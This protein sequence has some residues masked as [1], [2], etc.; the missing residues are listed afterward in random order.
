MAEVV[1]IE[2]DGRALQV[3]PGSRLLDIA[4]AHG[5]TIPRFC[6]HKKLSLAASCRMCLVEVEKA[7]K[8]M[9]ACSTQ[10]ME[11][12]VVHTR[13][14]RAIASQR[15][16]MEF[17]L[18]NHPLDCPICD[19]GGE[20]QLQEMAMGYGNDSSNYGETKRE[21]V[22]PDLGP[23]IAT[24]MNRCIHCT[25]CVRFGAEIAGMMELGAPGRGETMHISTF[26]AKTVDSEISAN[27]I[28]LC[29]VGALTSKPFRYKARPWELQGVE[30]VSLHD[31]MT[32]PI[33]VDSRRG[34]VM[35][36]VPA[37]AGDAWIADRD[38]FAY[39]GL[40]SGDRLTRPMIKRDGLWKEVEWDRALTFAAEGLQK[41][42]KSGGG[43]GVAALAGTTST[44][45]EYYLLQKLMRGL[46]SNHLD[47]RLR[48]IDF[49]D[50]ERA[51]IYPGLGQPLAAIA[52]HDSYLLIGTDLR[53]EQPLL[54]QKVREANRKGAKVLVVNPAPFP[55][56]MSLTEEIITTPSAL[57]TE[58]AAIAAAVEVSTGSAALQ[59]IITA[60]EITPHHQRI[61]AALRESSSGQILLGGIALAHPQLS[62]LRALAEQIAA[63]CNAQLGYAGAGGNSAGAALAGFL[64]HYGVGGVALAEKGKSWREMSASEI[65]GVVLLNLEPELDGVD[66]AALLAMLRQTSFNVALTAFVSDEM[67][68]YADVLLPLATA[69]ETSGTA[70]NGAGETVTL[71][72]ALPLPGESRPGWKVLRVLGNLLNL[73]G[74]EQMSSAEVTTEVEAFTTHLDPAVQ[75]GASQNGEIPESFPEFPQGDGLQRVVT[76]AL[77][78]SDPV[79][80]R[81]P[82]LQ[83]TAIAARGRRVH[84]S[85][86]DGE[87]L[88]LSDGDK[89]VIRQGSQSRFVE[90]TLQPNQ[91]AG[92]VI[93]AVGEAGVA[94]FNSGYIEVSG[95]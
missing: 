40:A 16:V 49:S 30:T 94:G 7:P 41:L 91:A 73:S 55:Q 4:D 47:S 34:E 95:A 67:E 87:A 18:V 38:R 65:K 63:S 2:I 11:G 28:D 33:R 45:E 61:A 89:V 88:A 6:Y 90:C 66:S 52:D 83:Q 3:E 59:K 79:V 21:V 69:Y 81:A 70:I 35:R 15:A 62:L 53:H 42:V 74:F 25:R 19:Q 23:L 48:Q 76:N 44:T 78:A 10:V 82:P 36:V 71:R 68:Q 9:P 13:S 60:A 72:A 27:V 58:L 39:T 20:C 5:I 51:P 50:E 84:L 54:A 1:N 43:D 93:V 85:A 12:M 77:Y 14:P 26:V 57:V 8:P 22:D 24:D 37:S 64:P 32:P 75:S 92:T 46:G 17:L 56:A 31:A 29:P 86:I 80:R